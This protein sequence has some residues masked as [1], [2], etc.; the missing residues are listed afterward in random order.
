M[1][2][3]DIT[4]ITVDHKSGLFGLLQ[5]FLTAYDR[6]TDVLANTSQLPDLT[7]ISSR[8]E[9][10]H[11]LVF[12]IDRKVD[13]FMATQEERLQAIQS[14]LAGVAEGVNTL[15]QQIADLKASNPALD[16]EISAIEATVKGIADDINGVVTEPPVEPPVEG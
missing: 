8:L 11:G 16:D 5:K 1:G 2:R 15:Q 4:F 9:L 12:N 10:I 14:G 6:R 3:E 13:E 7:L